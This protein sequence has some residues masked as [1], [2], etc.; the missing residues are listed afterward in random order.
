MKKE[1]ENRQ[2]SALFE[3]MTSLR[4]VLYAMDNKVATGR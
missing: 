1:S 3:G 2:S 4:A